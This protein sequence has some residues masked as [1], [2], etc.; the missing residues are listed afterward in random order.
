MTNLKNI[1]ELLGTLTNIKTLTIFFRE[2]D[3][4]EKI[5]YNDYQRTFGKIDE[6]CWKLTNVDEPFAMRLSIH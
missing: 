2:T 1:D 3:E 4:L 5:L 6:L